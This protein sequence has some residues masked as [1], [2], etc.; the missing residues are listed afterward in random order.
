MKVTAETMQSTESGY[1][2]RMTY[3]VLSLLAVV[4]LPLYIYHHHTLFGAVANGPVSRV[5]LLDKPLDPLDLARRLNPEG[6][7]I[8][9]KRIIAATKDSCGA[10]AEP[11]IPKGKITAVTFSVDHTERHGVVYVPNS[12]PTTTDTRSATP[13]PMLVL[14]HGL[15]DDCE[16]FMTATG[17]VPYAEQHGF[18]LVSACGSQGYLGTA[19]NSGTCCGFSGDKPNDVGFARQIVKDMSQ[20]VCVEERKVMAVGFS[21]GAMLAE[22]LACEAPDVFRAAA[23]IGGV[24]EMRPGNA[25][26]LLRCTEKVRAKRHR[27]SVLMVHGTRD[28]MVPWDGNRLLGFP[29]AEANLGEWVDRNSCWAD[30]KNTT[31]HTKKY[32]NVIFSHC[33]SAAVVAPE[34]AVAGIRATYQN[35]MNSRGAPF[36]SGAAGALAVCPMPSSF[37]TQARLLGNLTYSMKHHGRGGKDKGEDGQERDEEKEDDH[38]DKR[39]KK[40]ARH[41]HKHHAEEGRHRK[42]GKRHRRRSTHK[43]SPGEEVQRTVYDDSAI[44]QIEFVRVEGGGHSWP[45]D[46]EFS[47]TDYIVQFGARVFHGYN[48]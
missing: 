23:S 28:V 1:V 40:S 36:L 22:V 7:P 47:T 9:M 46:N 21:N 17:F 20:V 12:Y 25:E 41:G 37:R 2:R 24:V 11:P 44:S 45:E 32:V 33:N 29:P 19:W 38:H 27:A 3:W 4:F 8:Y 13:V 10:A 16:H 39:K 31:I 35:K 42:G 26:G 14:F 34:D 48:A 5:T 43:K 18:V 6:K 30:E 15:N